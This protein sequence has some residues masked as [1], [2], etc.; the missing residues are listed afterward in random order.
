MVISPR[1]KDWGP[2]YLRFG[3]G[4][5]TDFRGETP[6]TALVQYRKTWLNRLGGEWLTEAQI[7]RENRIFTEFYQP[8]DERG[9]WFVAPYVSLSR[10]SRPVFLGEDRIAEYDAKEARVGVD[11][12][13]VL[14]TWGELRLGPLWRYVD[15]KTDTGSPILPPITET[16]AG[17]KARLFADQLD[18]PWFPRGGYRIAGSAYVADRAF[19]SDQSYERY[20]AE[21]SVAKSLGPHTFNFSVAGG[22]DAHSNMPAYET[23][24]LGGPLRLSGYRIGEFSGQRMA[25]ARVM[26]Y[27]RV[28]PLPSLL[29][30]GVYA[31]V[32]LEA[33]TIQT[34]FDSRL[35]KGTIFSGSVF[36]GAETFAG[37]AYF[38][39]GMGESGRYSLYLLL[40]VP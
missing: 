9:R 32:S 22:T 29:G 36:L 6:F 3:L 39:F 18:N 35:P 7:G 15:A 37:P 30:S 8:V 17:I 5:A 19:G 28:L 23:F 34:R 13:A 12:G 26:Y 16:S 14:G 2:D 11:A 33:G 25:F 24:T 4:F 31:G 1:E 27:N 40:G 38:G 21:A 10:S 20:E